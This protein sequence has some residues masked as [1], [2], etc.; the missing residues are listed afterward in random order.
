[1]YGTSFLPEIA[2]GYLADRRREAAAVRRARSGRRPARLAGSEV[3]S[4]SGRGCG[5]VVRGLA[6]GAA[7]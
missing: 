6:S 3:R 4:P 1:M 7:S 2:A 5:P